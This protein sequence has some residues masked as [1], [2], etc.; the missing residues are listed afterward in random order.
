MKGFSTL[1][2]TGLA[3]TATLANAAAL[4][5]RQ[6]DATGYSGVTIFAA[7]EGFGASYIRFHVQNNAD[8]VTDGALFSVD[9][10]AV[11]FPPDPVN[12]GPTPAEYVNGGVQGGCSNPNATWTW[13]GSQFET[14]Y[15]W[16]SGE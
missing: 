8:G 7:S 10:S 14:V 6:D 2:S 9:C 4:L 15:T 5:P 3:L 1:V 11:S 13:D 12:G 16:D